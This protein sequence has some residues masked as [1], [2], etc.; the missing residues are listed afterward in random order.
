MKNK[1]IETFT[2]EMWFDN[3]VYPALKDHDD[4]WLRELINQY[5]FH[6][7][8]FSENS[9]KEFL[10][11]VYNFYTR[12]HARRMEN[13]M[14][15]YIEMRQAQ[16]QENRDENNYQII[17]E[18]KLNR[19]TGKLMQVIEMLPLDE[20]KQKATKQIMKDYVYDCINDNCAVNRQIFKAM[21]EDGLPVE[22]NYFN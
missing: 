14:T 10:N 1:N 4:I 13:S 11:F 8:G 12:M 21:L 20:Q 2:T 18:S 22:T 16:L 5:K 15:K 6:K 17:E 3:Y 7:D 19:L 9:K